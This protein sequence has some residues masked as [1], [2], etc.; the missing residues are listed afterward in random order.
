MRECAAQP[1]LAAD[2]LKRA[3]EGNVSAQRIMAY[4]H[5]L[6][7]FQDSP[8]KVR[9]MFADLTE[10]DLEARF[11]VPYRSGKSFLSGNEVV[12]ASRIKKVTILKTNRVSAA[13][14]KDIQDKSWK[15]VQEFNRNSDSMV[16]ISPGRGYDAEDIVE[17][18]NDVTAEFISG[19]PGHGGGWGVVSAVM[20]HPWVSAIGTGL[21]VAALAYWLG[22][23]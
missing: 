23:Q 3:A 4:Y 9:C 1:R 11:L 8:D 10:R 21:A 13:E 6:L 16:L 5:V 2:A 14:L 18:G 15:E 17:A 22:W 7:T 19:P 12:E 20:N